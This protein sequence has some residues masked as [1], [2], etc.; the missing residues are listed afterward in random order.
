MTLIAM[1]HCCD[2]NALR[3]RFYACGLCVRFCFL[4]TFFLIY[5]RAL[6]VHLQYLCLC[7]VFFVLS[8]EELN[9]LKATGCGSSIADSSSQSLSAG[10]Q[11]GA[12]RFPIF[13]KEI[14]ALTGVEAA[15]A[16]GQR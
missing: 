10:P 6:N 11:Q 2:D 13:E 1:T 9:R 16:G 3:H 7:N 15:A 5:N 12:T 4:C 8:E 14:I